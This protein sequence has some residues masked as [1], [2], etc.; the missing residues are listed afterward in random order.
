MGKKVGKRFTGHCPRSLR[1]GPE[2]FHDAGFQVLADLVGNG[3]LMAFLRWFRAKEDLLAAGR[4]LSPAALLLAAIQAD[5]HLE[6]T[7]GQGDGIHGRGLDAS[8]AEQF[9]DDAI[10][11]VNHFLA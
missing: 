11:D 5:N 1:V 9:G 2:P 8:S 7:L 10:D 3:P 4:A 6:V